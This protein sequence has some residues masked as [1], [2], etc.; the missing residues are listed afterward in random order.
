MKRNLF[1]FVEIRSWGVGLGLALLLMASASASACSIFTLTDTNRTLFCNNE[2]SEV[3]Q[4]RIWFVP[5]H[6][7]HWL[8]GKHYGCAFVGYAN[9]WG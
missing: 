9:L 5:T 7:H 6:G 1:Q 2:D 3:A 8:G 4:T